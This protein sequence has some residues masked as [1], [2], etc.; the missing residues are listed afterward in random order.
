MQADMIVKL[1]NMYQTKIN[2][3]LMQKLLMADTRLIKYIM[4]NNIEL[5]KL[6]KYFYLPLFNDFDYE[7]QVMIFEIDKGQFEKMFEFLKSYEP[8]NTKK[9]LKNS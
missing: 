6:E 5:V 8:K 4:D 1:C 7:T 3:R 9:V 2:S